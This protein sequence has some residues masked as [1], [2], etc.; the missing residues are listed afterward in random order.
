MVQASEICQVVA[1]IAPI[2]LAESWDNVGLLLGRSNRDVRRVMTCLTLTNAVAGEAI[3]RDVQMVIT[4]HPIL[5]R[6]TKRITDETAEG[7]LLLS[8]VEAGI[9]VYSPHTAFDSAAEG[10]NQSLAESFGLS[11]IQP[12]RAIE[13]QPGRGSGRFGLLEL[14]VPRDVFLKT[15]CR[16][17]DADYLEFC[18]AGPD[19]VQWVGVACGAAA[20]F[21]EDASRAECDTFVTGEAGF[22]SVLECQSLGMNLILTGHYRSERPGVEDLAL[23][24]KLRLPAVEIFASTSDQDPLRLFTQETGSGPD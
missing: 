16:T 17:I 14:P 7:R 6:G 18:P 11:A 1:E 10:I 15:V 8:L 21:L 23:K 22:H 3:R 5:F 13:E 20:E 9:V 19:L 12:L 2:R 4:H 24:L